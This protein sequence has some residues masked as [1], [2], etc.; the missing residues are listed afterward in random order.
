MAVAN[1]FDISPIG[2]TAAVL[3]DGSYRDIPGEGT[4]TITPEAAPVSTYPLLNGRAIKRIGATPPPNG[5]ITALFNGRHPVMEFLR[6]AAGGRKAVTM[7][8]RTAD[9]DVYQDKGAST[10]VSGASIAASDGEITF[11]GTTTPEEG[12]GDTPGDIAE[13]DIINIDND[14]KRVIGRVDANGVFVDPAPS[15]DVAEDL[16]TL[17]TP[18]LEQTARVNVK[19]FGGLNAAASGDVVETNIEFEYVRDPGA[20]SIV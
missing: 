14:E 4:L 16:Y 11:S 2:I 1:D 10:A 12:S 7:R 15:A 13:G 18:Q 19:T 8:I 17:A 20:W 6:A 5:S 3:M 9:E